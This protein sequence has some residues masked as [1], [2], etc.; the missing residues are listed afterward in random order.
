MREENLKHHKSKVSQVLH[1]IKKQISTIIMQQKQRRR[2]TLTL[3]RITKYGANSFVRNAWLS[4]AATAVMTVTL[5]IIF[6]SLLARSILMDTVDDIKN[7]VELSIYLKK[8]VSNSDIEKMKKSIGDLKTVTNITY[9][10]PQE[11]RDKFAR[12]NSADIRI[13]KALIESNN[14]FF[15]IFNIKLV[16]ISNSTELKNLVENNKLIKSSLDPDHPPT[17]ESDRNEAIK[18]ISNTINFAEKVGILAGS[19]FV[20]I[21]SLIIFNTIRMAIFNR[22][23]EIY[24][25]KLIG[26]NKSF[27][28]GPFL[29][30]AVICGT[31]AAILASI[32]GYL[33]IF[34]SKTKLEVYG[35]VISPVISFLQI[36]GFLVVMGLIVVGS[37]IG[38]VSALTA[39]RK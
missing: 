17:Y 33:I 39:T 10:S 15:G 24:M 1:C 3:W 9:T 28:A 18:N 12:K 6:G 34:L 21:A 29:V 37:F 14:E 13:R 4:V 22:R 35:I 20:I 16:D 30:E 11:V 27:I 25:M 26:A 7:K 36:Y 5:V 8:G 19:I 23:E 32:I 38:V 31:I 2:K